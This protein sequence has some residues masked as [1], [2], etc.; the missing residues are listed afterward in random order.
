VSRLLSLRIRIQT[1]GFGRCV[2]S[3]PLLDF[4]HVPSGDLSYSARISV[5]ILTLIYS[6]VRSMSL[7]A[8]RPLDLE[9]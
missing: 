2:D 7:E 3:V 9:V 5:I 6:P 1:D 8:N 4:E